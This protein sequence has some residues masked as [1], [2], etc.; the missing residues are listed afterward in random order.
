MYLIDASIIFKNVSCIHWGQH[1]GGEKQGQ[2]MTI[3]RFLTDKYGS[4][5]G[6]A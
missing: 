1:Y 6:Q 2:P 4:V 5:K 3:H